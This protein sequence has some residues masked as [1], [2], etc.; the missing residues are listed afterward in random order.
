M[1]N[2]FKMPTKSTLKSRISTINNA[3][4]ISMTPWDNPTEEEIEEMYEQ[5]KIK[6]GQC[7][8]CLRDA[9]TA[10]HINNLVRGGEPS[11][12][13]TEKNNLVPC[14]TSCNSSKNKKSFEIWYTDS[15]TQEN[16]KN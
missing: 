15:K 13:I 9:T 8:Y 6:P 12:Y 11:G 7:A 10:D 14:C 1:K 2:K 4:V 3:F 16:L 5:L